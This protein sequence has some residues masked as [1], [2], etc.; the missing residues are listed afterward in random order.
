MEE[1]LPAILLIVG[2][3]FAGLTNYFALKSSLHISGC[4]LR[5]F[6][7]SKMPNIRKLIKQYKMGEVEEPHLANYLKWLLV[8]FRFFYIS[9]TLSVV[10]MIIFAL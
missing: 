8:S 2:F 10:I 5:T 7:T 3:V 6:S 4:T 1:N 9:W